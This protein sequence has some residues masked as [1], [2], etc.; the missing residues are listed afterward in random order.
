MSDFE[1][2]EVDRYEIDVPKKHGVIRDDRKVQLT[3]AYQTYDIPVK[4]QTV[5]TSIYLEVLNGETF[6]RGRRKAMMWKCAYE[7][8]KEEK[9]PMDPIL[10]S[11]K[12]GVDLKQMR[13]AQ[14]EFH[15]RIFG[16]VLVGRFPKR[17][18]SAFE[19]IPSLAKAM[20]VDTTPDLL[21]VIQS[22]IP[23]IY[24]SSPLVHRDAPRDV[25]IGILH[26]LR[27]QN[28]QP[29]TE[30]QTKDI[31]LISHASLTRVLKAIV[32]LGA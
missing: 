12:F 6:K 7:A 17:H 4:I 11:M 21:D 9:I 8:Y 10:L 23:E 31:T 15:E 5:A 3:K 28:G 32:S 18:L 30:A 19:L 29:I 1:D 14:D 13:F 22:F 24:E 25:A 16:T 27:N 2:D 20:N 26:W